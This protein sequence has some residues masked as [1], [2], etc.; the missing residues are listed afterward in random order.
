ML[1]YILL[2]LIVGFA[3]LFDKLKY[4]NTI[5]MFL[6]LVMLIFSGFRVGGTGIGDYDAYLRL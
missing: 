2:T 4:Q 3:T 5:F 6:S 1:P